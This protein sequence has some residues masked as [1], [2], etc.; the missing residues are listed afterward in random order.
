MKDLL[1]QLIRADSTPDKGEAAAAEVIARRFARHG[2]DCRIDRWNGNR[3]NVIAH[4]KT[5]QRRPGLLFLGHLDVVSPGEEAW[6]HPPFGA[7]EEEGRLYGRG[8]VD[9]KGGIAAVVAAICQVTDSRAAL[10]GDIVFAATAGEETDSAGVQRF[11]QHR[12]DLPQFVGV[13]IPEPTDLSVVT[14]H[15][16]LFWLKITTRGKA[17]HSSMP[18]RG[19]NAITS[20]RRVLDALEQYRIPFEAHP[21]LGT[22][23]LSVNTIHGGEAVNI[24]PDRCT[25]GV[26]I[27]TLPGQDHE[28]LRYDIECILA[29]LTTTVPQFDAELTIERSAQAM[30]TDPESD[31]VKRFCAAVD[32]DLTNVIGFTT[33]ASHVL[34][35]GVPIV[36]FGPGKP[37]LCHQVD[38]YIGLADVRAGADFFKQVILRFLT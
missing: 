35:L 15:R 11:M 6:D 34:P 18:Q 8:A 30:E 16:G 36:I 22:S 28:T 37:K 24:I 21:L 29:Q 25:I 5:G 19:V 20:M 32:V 2:V 23:S 17:A 14:A 26:D 3:A 33:D 7:V 38:E 10:Q 31:F 13:V 4:V 1:K 27:R 9:M 12:S